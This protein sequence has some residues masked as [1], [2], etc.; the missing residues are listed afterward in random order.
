MLLVA[1]AL[2]ASAPRRQLVPE[3]ARALL[4]GDSLVV[5]AVGGLA[6]ALPSANYL[7]ALAAILAAHAA[8]LTQ[9]KALLT[10]N[11]VAL[12]VAE[13]PLISYAVAPHKTRERMDRLQAWLRSRGRRDVALLVA[14]AGCL[15][16][17]IGL[18]NL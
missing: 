17:V 2:A 14:A 13:I 5:A 10:F 12:A 15:M 11:V 4:Q 16:L 18:I 8:P 1:G 9:V 6:T 3:R 7:G